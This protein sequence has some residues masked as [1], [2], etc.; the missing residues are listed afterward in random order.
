MQFFG[1]MRDK[2]APALSDA[3]QRLKEGVDQVVAG[4]GEKMQESK[5]KSQFKALSKE[6]NEL[7]TALGVK[8]YELYKSEQL[9]T[10][11]CVSEFTK[12]DEIEAQL[13]KKQDEMDALASGADLKE[14]EENL[15]APDEQGATKDS[16]SETLKP[17][18]A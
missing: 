16:Q 1:K 9:E 3:S 10:L 14:L 11:S 12:L 5:L 6:K 18:Q 13:A 17:E 15:V 8:V 4:A 2:V 7:I